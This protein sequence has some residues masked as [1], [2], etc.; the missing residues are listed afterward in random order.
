M[1]IGI[2]ADYIHEFPLHSIEAFRARNALR[3]INAALLDFPRQDTELSAEEFQEVSHSLGSHELGYVGLSDGVAILYTTPEGDIGRAHRFI[4]PKLGDAIRYHR[5]AI[6][7]PPPSE[8]Q[9]LPIDL[10]GIDA[11]STRRVVVNEIDWLLHT[12]RYDA[13]RGFSGNS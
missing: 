4:F 1:D 9:D 7:P 12:V 11:I 13:A 5:E 8:Y 2:E 3:R 10:V 6:N